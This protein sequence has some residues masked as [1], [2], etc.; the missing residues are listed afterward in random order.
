VQ[1]TSVL[2]DEGATRIAALDNSARSNQALVDGMHRDVQ[3]FRGTFQRQMEHVQ[4]M[5]HE[6][7]ALAAALEDGNR[8]ARLLDETSASLTHTS[9]ALMQRLSN[10]QA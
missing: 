2:M 1:D 5:D 10:L 9:T 4:V 3:G 7:Q 6:S 8:H